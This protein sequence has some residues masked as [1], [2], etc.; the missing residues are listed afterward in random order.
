VDAKMSDQP[1]ADT[2]NDTEGS[3]DSLPCTE[4]QRLACTGPVSDAHSEDQ[5]GSDPVRNVL[6]FSGSNALQLL[7]YTQG[8]QEDQTYENTAATMHHLDRYI[9]PD[10]LAA[11]V[12][13]EDGVIDVGCNPYHA[14]ELPLMSDA[15]PG[16]IRSTDEI[17]VGSDLTSQQAAQLRQLLR[18]QQ[19]LFAF[20]PAQ[21]GRCKTT[22]FDITLKPEAKPVAQ[23]PYRM[24]PKEK[25]ILKKELDRMLEQGLIKP[26]H[27]PWS[28]PIVLV[29]KKDGTTRLTIDYRR[30]NAVTEKREMQMVSLEEVLDS[31]GDASWFALADCNKGFLQIP[32]TENASKLC[33]FTS[34]TGT[35]SPVTMSMGLVNAPACYQ[36][37]M[38]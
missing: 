2:V 23:K 9:P 11:G 5:L 28:S 16:S 19:D 33:S 7:A 15:A 1:Q 14:G 30:L 37:C 36:E 12:C 3:I 10:V 20:T 34:F 4:L 27:S 38:N 31:L 25:D 13:E 26:S 6:P 18:Q 24:S 8:F 35:W 17:K 32:C 29:P 21:L 22:V